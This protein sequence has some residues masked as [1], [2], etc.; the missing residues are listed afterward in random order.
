VLDGFP[1]TLPQGQA[2]FEALGASAVDRAIELHVPTQVVLPR[3]AAR[4]VC[5]R[6]GTSTTVAPG[7]TELP[8]G[9]GGTF[10]RRADDT[11]EAIATRLALYDTRRPRCSP[12][13]TASGSSPPST[14]PVART[15][16]PS[17]WPRRWPTS[18][19]RRSAA[20]SSSP[21]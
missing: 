5:D 2:L 6:C 21:A 17:A 12:G 14:G 8:C 15:W 10:V 7:V 1:R 11:D 13:S 9:C 19:G 3:L 4:R 18:S 20:A 16:S